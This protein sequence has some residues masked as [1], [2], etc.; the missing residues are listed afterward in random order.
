MTS[1]PARV[2]AIDALRGVAIAAMALQHTAFFMRGSFQGEN[3]AGQPAQLMSWP[4]WVSGL[5]VDLNAPT[6]WLLAGVSV[7]LM[8]AKYRAD[9]LTEAAI[10]RHMLQRAGVIA[11]L[12]LTVCD[13][14][15]RLADPIVPYTHVLL[16]LAVS[17][18]ALSV[19]RR[20]PVGV[21]AAITFALV[22]VYQSFLPRMVDAWS[23]VPQWW[24][25]LLVGYRTTGWPA[26]EFALAGWFPLI[27]LGYLLGY[28]LAL[29]R[30]RGP[31]AW[32][33]V[34]GAL[35]GGWLLLRSLGGFGDLAPYQPGQEWYRFIIMN[36]TP[37]ALTYV[38]FHLGVASAVLA[39]LSW[40]ES[41]LDRPPL[42]WLTTLG[43]ASLF[44]FAGHIAVFAP[45]TRVARFA[46]MPVPRVAVTYAV[47][48]AGMALLVPGAAWYA[49]MRRAHPGSVWLP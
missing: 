6:F 1:R 30:L 43:K 29:G 26:I 22:V 37:L 38:L 16:S 35:F 48:F 40:A 32:A 11:L 10:T 2:L 33:G 5:A 9:G 34:A 20:L 12:D 49:R 4:H 8:V 17:F 3:Y 24:L 19:L 21:F 15:W 7:P 36:K 41:R 39:L 28:G 45:L 44:V 31:R 46:E 18:A 13:W 47:F 27:G 14:L 42:G 25:A 23:E